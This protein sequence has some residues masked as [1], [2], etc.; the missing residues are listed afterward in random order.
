[1]IYFTA[2]LH[3]SHTNIIKYCNRP[4]KDA[5]H[6]DEIITKNFLE[7][8][9]PEDT[10]YIL[11]DISFRPEPVEKFFSRLPEG[12]KIYY[13][14]GNH[15]FKLTNEFLLKYCVSVYPMID[16]KIE[17]QKITLCH[18]AMRTWNCSC[19]GAWDLHGHSHGTLPPLGKQMDVGVDT[20]HFYPYSFYEIRKT[21]EARGENED[22]GTKE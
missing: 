16:I 18:Y 22:E 1:M 3:L 8:L 12:L 15:D 14:R 7:V 20:N 19:H 21:M 9:K 5:N 13:I 6:M 2:D 11:G 17:G 4:F 10:L